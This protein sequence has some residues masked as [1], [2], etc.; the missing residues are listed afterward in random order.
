LSGALTG[1]AL[2][3]YIRD[4]MCSKVSSQDRNELVD[5]TQSLLARLP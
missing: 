4:V 2:V 1:E 3:H 5:E